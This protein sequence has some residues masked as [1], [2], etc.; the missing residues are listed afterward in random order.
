MK[1]SLK[2]LGEYIEIQ[3]YFSKPNE[4][5]QLLTS[6]GIEV[7]SIEN[8]AKQFEYVVIGHILQKH[9]HPNADRLTVC[10][11]S[12]GEGVVHQ[13]VCGARNH[14]EGDRVVVALPGAVLPGN[15]VIKRAKIRDVDSGGMLCSEKELGLKAE[16]EG[17]MLLPADAPVGQPL[18]KYLG[19]D[20]IL[21]ELKVTPNRSDCLSHFGLAREIGALTG[22]AVRF[23][24]ESIIEHGG[25]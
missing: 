18:A 15:F 2:W 8:R 6:A 12:T 16:S 1:I 24:I 20:D 7:E 5:A 9:Q 10:Q 23:P 11:V 3:D 25:Y 14:N 17:I 4:L 19:F 22:R 13:I 21:F